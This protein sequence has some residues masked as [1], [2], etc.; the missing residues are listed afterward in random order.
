MS[1]F[2]P[3]FGV[4]LAMAIGLLVLG[5]VLIALKF[6]FGYFDCVLRGAVMP[7][8]PVSKDKPK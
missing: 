2:L 5:P 1:T 8:E 7:K 6:G 4:L 3:V